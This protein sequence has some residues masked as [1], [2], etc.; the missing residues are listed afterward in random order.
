MRLEEIVLQLTRDEVTPP[1]TVGDD[2]LDEMN[3]ADA[4][5]AE[6]DDKD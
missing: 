4:Q 2:V 5:D 6:E 3:L 1:E